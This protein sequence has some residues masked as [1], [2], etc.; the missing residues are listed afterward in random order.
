MRAPLLLASGRLALIAIVA[1]AGCGQLTATARQDALAMTQQTPLPAVHIDIVVDRFQFTKPEELCNQPLVAEVVV[2]A[3]GEARWNTEDGKRPP[4]ATSGEITRHGYFIYT[5]VPFSS[6]TSLRAHSLPPG[7][8]YMSIGGQV[9]QD[10]YRMD[11][12]PQLS[13]VGGHYILVITA[14][15]LRKGITPADTLLVS[16]AFPIDASGKVIIQQAGDPNEPGVGPVQPEIA[17]ALPDLKAT[18]ARCAA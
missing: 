18:L 17:V 5:P 8:A 4:V 16:W 1:I 3:H 13:G 15:A 12:Y 7:E 2:S 11:G 14:P 10:T 9:G 6:F